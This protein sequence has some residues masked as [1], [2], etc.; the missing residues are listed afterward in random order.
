MGWEMVGA[1]CGARLVALLSESPQKV[2]LATIKCLLQTVMSGSSTFWGESGPLK[3]RYHGK[4]ARY[5]GEIYG[6]IS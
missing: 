1:V 5:H 6:N 2:E 3:G 4:V